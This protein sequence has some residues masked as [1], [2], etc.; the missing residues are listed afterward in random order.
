MKKGV[1]LKKLLPMENYRK[2]TY[3]KDFLWIK[4]RRINK[5]KLKYKKMKKKKRTIKEKNMI[6]RRGTK[7][8]KLFKVKLCSLIKKPHNSDYI[9]I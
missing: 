9:F 5:D 2:I 3:E 7:K 4:G 8:I 6:I 1:P